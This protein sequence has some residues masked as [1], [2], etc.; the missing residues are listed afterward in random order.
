MAANTLP[1]LTN[2]ALALPKLERLRLAQSLWESIE[3]DELPGLTEAQLQAEL[4]DRLRDK[5]DANWKT[6]EQVMAEARREYQ[7]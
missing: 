1:K 4:R 3:D 2:Q 7:A 5:P 6:H